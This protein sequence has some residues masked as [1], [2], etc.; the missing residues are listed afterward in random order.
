MTKVD[1]DALRITDGN[2]GLVRRDLLTQLELFDF[3]AWIF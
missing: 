2:H 3:V 1:A